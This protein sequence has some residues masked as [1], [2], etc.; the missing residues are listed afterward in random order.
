MTTQ[1]S[2][3]PECEGWC[4]W[5]Q[6]RSASSAAGVEMSRSIASRR[7]SSRLRSDNRQRWRIQQ[8]VAVGRGTGSRVSIC[9][10]RRPFGTRQILLSWR[11][12]HSRVA[13]P[14]GVRVR[15]PCIQEAG[16]RPPS[17]STRQDSLESICRARRSRALLFYSLQLNVGVR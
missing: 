14:V 8:V 9:T 12:I 16:A 17:M 15:R 4:S 5:R 7:L 13:S 11:S 3:R 1:F 6:G 10:Q 2:L